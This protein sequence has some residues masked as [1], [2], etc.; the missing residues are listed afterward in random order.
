M[1]GA[2]EE[3]APKQRNKPAKKQ[4]GPAKAVK[5]LFHDSALRVFDRH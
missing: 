2:I 5:T 3:F 1:Q 4:I